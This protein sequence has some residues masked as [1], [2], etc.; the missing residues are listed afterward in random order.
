MNEYLGISEGEICNR[1]GCTGTIQLRPVENCSCHISAPCSAC[2]SPRHYCNMCD[3]EESEEI[4]EFRNCIVVPPVVTPVENFLPKKLRELDT[5][6]V[7]WHSFPHTHFSMIKR[8][9]YP[10]GT[11]IEEVAEQVKGTFG[12]RFTYFANGK[13]EFI[14]YTD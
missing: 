11:A 10:L 12:G 1:E 2:T 13:F 4:E 5:T 14:A 6:K 7:D 3:W 8:G 9:V